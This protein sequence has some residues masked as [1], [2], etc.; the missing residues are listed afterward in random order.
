MVPGAMI[1]KPEGGFK[2]QSSCDGAI[3]TERTL[4]EMLHKSLRIRLWLGCRLTDDTVPVMHSKL[5]I[6]GNRFLKLIFRY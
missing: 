6:V 5:K 2:Y 3:G 4:V 1:S